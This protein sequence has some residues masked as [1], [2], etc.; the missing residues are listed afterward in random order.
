MDSP[1]RV[2]CGAPECE[3]QA[4]NERSREFHR[5]YKERTGTHYAY[6]FKRELE[7]I[8]CGK[9][10]VT[11]TVTAKFCSNACQAAYEH[12]PD[13]LPKSA[14][15][16]RKRARH[17][18]AARR[19]AAAA[20]GTRGTRGGRVFTAGFCA[21]CGKAS[22]VVR[23]GPA[24]M[25][26]CSDACRKNE[27]HAMRRAGHGLANRQAIYQRDGFRCQIP[28][29]LFGAR[30]VAMGKK[31]PHPKAPVL[32]HVIPPDEARGMGM[33]DEEINGPANL[34]C[35]HFLCN[36]TRRERGGNDQLALIG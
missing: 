28:Q 22:V 4:V 12:G 31:T 21:K 24:V 1:R 3:R 27:R 6:Q 17:R 16:R 11:A 8:Q 5:D 19:L 14:E 30:P 13:R 35:A 20:R 18:A 34:R 25:F 33:A 10:W 9:R 32:D 7:C 2:Q 29:C 26:F 23:R 36:S 15:R